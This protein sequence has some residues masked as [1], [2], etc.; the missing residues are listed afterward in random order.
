MNCIAGLVIGVFAYIDKRS[1]CF[2]AERIRKLLLGVEV[3]LIVILKLSVF[4]GVMIF[5]RLVA[6]DGV[7]LSVVYNMFCSVLCTVGI[8]LDNIG[9]SSLCVPALGILER[10]VGVYHLLT[11]LLSVFIVSSLVCNTLVLTGGSSCIGGCTA[12][13]SICIVRRVFTAL[14]KY[15]E[16]QNECR[17]KRCYF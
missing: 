4:F 12:L 16:N 17:K 14:S 9:Y 15:S 7:T 2:V 6:L 3:R 5:C 8:I 10:S 1:V 13:L 11:V